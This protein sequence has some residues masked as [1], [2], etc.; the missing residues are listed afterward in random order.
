MT[1]PEI[2]RAIKATNIRFA[3][4]EPTIPDYMSVLVAFLEDSEA[5]AAVISE[6]KREVFQGTDA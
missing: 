3:H 1:R 5:A 6:W 2:V 4:C